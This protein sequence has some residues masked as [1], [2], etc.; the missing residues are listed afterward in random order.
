M[1]QS[2]EKYLA[3]NNFGDKKPVPAVRLEEEFAKSPLKKLAFDF[4]KEIIT[5]INYTR[6]D[7]AIENKF[8]TLKYII[9][10]LDRRG[11]KGFVKG[12]VPLAKFY[13]KTNNVV[14][15]N[16]QKIVKEHIE[17]MGR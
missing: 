1:V 4:E 16:S 2:I 5:D 10:W 17:R 13:D 7:K 6:L 11:M 9:P 12:Q 15:L 3:A 8:I 14:V